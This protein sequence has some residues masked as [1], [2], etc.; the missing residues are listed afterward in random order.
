MLGCKDFDMAIRSSDSHYI[1]LLLMRKAKSSFIILLHVYRNIMDASILPEIPNPHGP[2]MS[3]RHYF[4]AL[5]PGTDASHC[6]RVSSDNLHKLVYFKLKSY[7]SWG[8]RTSD[9]DP[10]VRL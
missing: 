4:I 10:H 2:I 3:T 5:G 8:R 6:I 9:I 1:F 7:W